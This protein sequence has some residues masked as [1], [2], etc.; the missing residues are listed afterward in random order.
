MRDNPDKP[1]LYRIRADHIMRGD[2]TTN[3]LVKENDVLYIPATYMAEVGYVVDAVTYPI[4]SVVSGARVWTEAPYAF[5]YGEE[6][7]QR[8]TPYPY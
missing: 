1:E 5:S 8:A 2:F 6:R 3:V 7:A 4:R